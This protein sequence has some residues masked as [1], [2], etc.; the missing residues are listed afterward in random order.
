MG[1]SK[2]NS[3]NPQAYLSD[4]GVRIFKELLKH[5]EEKGI[6]EK[7][8]SFELSMLANE[9]DKYETAATQAADNPTGLYNKFQNGT[10]QVNAF[11]T[12]M[13]DSYGLIMKHSPK[14]G[15]NPI[16]REKILGLSKKEKVEKPFGDI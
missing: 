16:D 7:I 9:F 4:N 12:I 13:K 1:N 8:D 14:F 10:V 5:C 6:S 11:H 15:L 2:G 3:I